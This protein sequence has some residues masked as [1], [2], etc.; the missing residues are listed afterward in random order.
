MGFVPIDLSPKQCQLIDLINIR[1][2]INKK[3]LWILESINDS[4]IDLIFEY[5]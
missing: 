4:V 2:K 3:N 1:V 5:N